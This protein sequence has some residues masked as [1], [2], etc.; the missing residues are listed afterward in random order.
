IRNRQL[1]RANRIA[2]RRGQNILPARGRGVTV[3]DHNQNVV[4]LV[5]HGIA[6]TTGQSVVPETAVTHEADG[7]LRGFLGVESGGARP[8]QT[9]AHGRSADVERRQDRKEV[10]TDVAAYV[11][12]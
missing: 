12:G 8:S 6:N 9:V 11:M 5:E 7:A 3:V 4:A 10:T 2:G 1:G